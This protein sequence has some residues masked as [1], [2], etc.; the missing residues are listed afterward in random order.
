MLKNDPNYLDYFKILKEVKNIS[1][2]KCKKKVRLAV[3]ADFASQQFVSILRVLFYKNGIN[4]EI[5]EADFD[6]IELEVYNP[7][8]E[9]YSFDPEIILIL[10]STQKLKQLYYSQG[11]NKT[12]FLENSLQ[13]ITSIW[14]TLLG[15]KDFKIIQSSFVI[16][17]ETIF[18]NFDSKVPTSL[19]S[20]VNSINSQLFQKS[21]EYKNVFINDLDKIASYHGRKNWFNDTLW[22]HSKTPCALEFLPYIAQN[23]LDIYLSFAGSTIKCVVLDLDNTLWGGVIGDDGLDGIALGHLGE[24]EAFYEFQEYILELKHRGII[25]AVCSKNDFENAVKPFREHP[26]MV[27]KEKDIAVFIANWNNKADNIKLI[28][29]SLNIGFDAIA[30]FDDNPYERNLVREFLPD[31]IIPELPEDS[32]EYVKHISELNLFETAFFTEEDK[33]RAEMYRVEFQRKELEKS[34]TD[35]SAY[36][37]SLEMKI[38]LE[39]FDSFHIPRIAQL[40]QRSNQFNLTTKRYSEAEC[41]T[42]GNTKEYLPLYIKLRDKYG[43]YGLISVVV[44]KFDMDTIYIDSWLMSC[45]VLARGVEQYAMNYI[46]EYAKSNDYKTVV[47]EYIPTSKNNMVKD[48]Y[49]KFEFTKVEENENKTIWKKQVTDYNKKE[50]FLEKE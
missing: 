42:F 4:A 28:K 48:F 50:V 31:V 19:Y 22:F 24:G 38:T 1:P 37:Q 5:Y 35:I 44:L 14:N 36:L 26:E 8:S 29:E 23:I 30:F 12:G 27:L 18:G 39:K 43:D 10:N 40:L 9:M 16:P 20:V 21:Q 33:N 2:E 32:A 7:A 17:V 45:R 34:F 25:L 6:A 46:F 13:K 47:G 15:K 41:E 49:E 11:E 3:L